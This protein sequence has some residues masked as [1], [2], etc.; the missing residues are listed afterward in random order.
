MKSVLRGLPFLFALSACEQVIKP[1]LPEHTPRLVLQA[2]FTPDSTWAAFVGR[3]TGI[4][5]AM[6]EREMSVADAEVDLLTG[7]QVIDRLEFFQRERV[8]MW[9]K[10]ALQ[11]GE[12]YSL[13]VAAPGFATIEATDAIPTPVPTAVVSYLTHTSDR[14]E[15]RIKG[16]MSIKLEIQDPPGE[17]NY[18]Q[19]RM[20]TF[21]RSELYEGSFTTQDPSIIADNAADEPFNESFYTAPFFKDTLFDGQTHQIELSGNYN[22]PEHSRF[23]VQVLYTSE[24]YYEYLR[25]SRLH[26]SAQDNPFAEPISVYSNVENGYGIF[27]GYSS[28]TFELVLE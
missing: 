4:L 22:A 14:S 17:T 9:E 23:Y 3:S 24:T 5:E 1:D 26:D 10:G 27:A 11:T 2:F 7:G 12:S 20:F 19:I 6:P 15:S 21:F 8:Y 28:Q 13:R 25:S 18:Y 16:D